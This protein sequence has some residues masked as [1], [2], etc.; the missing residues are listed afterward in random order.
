MI[1]DLVLSLN[2]ICKSVFLLFCYEAI[3]GS[4][5]FHCWRQKIVSEVEGKI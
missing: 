1:K 2:K 3:N 4:F 5:L